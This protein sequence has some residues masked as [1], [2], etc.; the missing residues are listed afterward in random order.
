[1]PLSTENISAVVGSI[2]PNRPTDVAW[3]QAYLNMVP[4]ALGGPV[5]KLKQDGMF[6]P[7]TKAAIEGFQRLQ[8]GKADGQVDPGKH[9]EQ[10]LIALES[11]PTT[12]PAIHIGAARRQA[13]IWMEAGRSAVS[14]N[15][16][17]SG[18]VTLDPNGGARFADFFG[19][20]FRLD[21]LKNAP[22]QQL[23]FIRR[24][25]EKATTLLRQD[26]RVLNIKFMAKEDELRPP[27]LAHRA[28]L[29]TGGATIL[30]NYKFTDFDDACGFGIGPFT[31]AAV[32]LQAAFNGADFFPNAT[33]TANELFIA[34][35]FAPTDLAIHSSGHCSFFCQGMSAGGSVPRPFRHAPD[36]AGGWNDQPGLA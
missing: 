1:L 27:R 10:K 23:V 9:T 20:V 29:S 16:D 26:I 34:S 14:R 3:I 35:G 21:I 25:F 2:G 12:R 7:K 11:E 18:K 17:A 31:R 19:L 8:F 13:Q 24:K 6:G 30:A 33:L 36:G 15:I 5:T 28:P 32:F 4:P 22:A